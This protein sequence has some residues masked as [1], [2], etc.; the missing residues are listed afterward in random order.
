MPY[1]L[2]IASSMLAIG[3]PVEPP[4]NHQ[5]RNRGEKGKSQAGFASDVRAIC[6]ADH[7]KG[8]LVDYHLPP[9]LNRP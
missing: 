5:Q 3:G 4:A 2:S 6:R 7:R 9:D 1:S 8:A